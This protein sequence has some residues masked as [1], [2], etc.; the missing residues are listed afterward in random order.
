M[1]QSKAVRVIR[2]TVLLALAGSAGSALAQ[3]QLVAF[4]ERYTATEHGNIPNE[5]F[6]HRVDPRPTEPASWLAPVAYAKG[7][8]HVHLEVLTKPSTRKT[9]LTICFDGEKPGYGCLDTDPYTAAGVYEMTRQMREPD[10]W[11]YGDIAWGQKRGQYHLV[12]KDPGLGGRQG[13]TPVSDFVPS[14]LRVVLTIVPP[15]GKYTAPGTSGAPADG[16]AGPAD[17]GAADAADAPGSPSAPDAATPVSA[18]DAGTTTPPPAGTGTP[19]PTAPPAGTSP[20]PRE[21]PATTARSTA[22]SGG[23]ATAP[24]VGASG[25]PVPLATVVVAV[26][27]AL[28]RRRRRR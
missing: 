17:G 20:P 5:T 13:G 24:V 28:V 23:C 26:V 7:T 15:G 12:V 25:M 2:C 16:G 11:Q 3:E 10:V 9:I 8:A 27:A 18:P 1:S 19:P 22:K 21:P 14:D 4:D 6:H